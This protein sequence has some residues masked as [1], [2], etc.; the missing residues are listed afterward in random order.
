M[1]SIKTSTGLASGID[2]AALIKALLTANQSAVTK[3]QNR[4]KTIQATQAGLSTIQAGLLSITTSA[5]TLSTKSTFQ[6]LKIQN[7]DPAQLSVTTSSAATAS[8]Q[9]FQTVRLATTDQSL[10]RGFA[11]ANQKLGLTGEIVVNQGGHL[12]RPTSLDLLNNGAGVRRGSIRITDRRGETAT[13]DL[14]KALTV[15][16]VVQAINGQSSAA[17]K[18]STQDG[19][20]VLQDTSGQTTNNLTVIDLNNGHAAED[21]GI[22]QSVAASTLTGS[23]VYQLSSD[24]SLKSLNDGN[25][26]RLR[27]GTAAELSVTLKDGSNLQVDLDSARTIGDVVQAINSNSANAGKLTAA[28][29]NGRLQLTD[30]TGG[31]GTLSV[32]ALPNTNAANV[33]GLTVSAAGNV[34]TGK[35]LS[36]GLDSVLLRN[37][38]GGQGIT[39]PGEISLTD[40]TGATAVVNLA[41]AESLDEVLTAINN[42]TTSGSVKLKLQASLD[43]SGTGIVITDTSG[44]TAS[45]LIIADVNGGTLAGNLNIDVNAATT[46]V[47]SG[48]LR[49]RSINE[50]T[51]L[52]KYAP[53]GGAVS[54]GSF[55]ITNS[56]GASAVINIGSATKTIGDVIDRINSA[57][58]NVTAELNETGD[59]F[60]LIDNA[61]GAGTLKVLDVGGSAAADLRLLGAAV[62][63]TDGKQRIVSR[64]A[65]IVKIIAD[66]T[67]TTISTKINTAGG[68]ARASVIDSGSAINP[69]RLSLT[70]TASGAD[71]R[72]VIDDGGLGFNFSKQVAGQDAVL[73]IGSDPASAFLKTS[74][75][76]T[77]ANAVTGYNVTLLKTGDQPAT[78]TGSLDTSSIGNALSTLVKNYNQLVGQID[79]LTKY[80]PATQ[81]RAALQGS[82]TVLQIESRITGLVNR[83]TGSPSSAVRSLA[84]VGVIIGAGGNLSF[85]QSQFETAV[86]E[87]PEEVIKLFT[88]ATSGFGVRLNTVL[89]D[90][91][92]TNKGSLTAE[93]NANDAHIQALDDQIERMN[94]S[95]AARQSYLEL[96][97]A[98]MEK[99]LSGL[100]SQ[101]DALTALANLAEASKVSSKN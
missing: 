93:M 6:S 22:E 84:D 60:V 46:S 2:T 71:N 57:G 64:D 53:S 21:L 3:I 15:D 56:A 69:F 87:H 8:V 14:T 66:D 50:A 5:Q 36:G 7:S 65:A 95:L 9:Q 41:Q 97:F 89:E 19:K 54:A 100:Q 82:G 10:S 74:S 48:S 77:F 63:G 79:T 34:I 40:R 38:R 61:A 24:V 62:T 59:G 91:T 32:D 39:A 58:I 27:S 16:D 94:A 72:L 11:D 44:Q 30:T 4:Q 67:L 20:I 86:A 55:S 17:V 68:T 47:S 78:V 25:G 80:D 33:L 13:I 101:Q 42:A 31:A 99:V 81:S 51:S 73:R 49:L 43:A 83:V 1:G 85:D 35:R 28:L 29:T 12:N 52:S 76:N 88:D 70:A 45:N 90:L 18:A 23:T 26:I 75:T 96:Q 98:N 92:D 37:L